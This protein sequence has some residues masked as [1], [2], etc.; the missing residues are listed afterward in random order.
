V[1]TKAAAIAQK[2]MNLYRNASAIEG[3][4][5]AVNPVL[6]KEANA[7]VMG[8]IERL[9][10][11]KFLS[12]HISDLKSGR[13]KMNSIDAELVP[14]GANFAAPGKISDDEY[15]ELIRAL[16]KFKPDAAHLDVIKSLSIVKKF[17]GNWQTG[18]GSV[19]RDSD[20][21][22]AWQ[23]VV[24]TDG[25]LRLWAR[26]AGILSLEPTE[27]LRAEVQAD[28]PEYETYLPMFGEEGKTLLARIRK[29][30]NS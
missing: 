29:L 7:A 22:A 20:G 6:M 19:L 15:D 9:P 17:E 11:G 4:W 13:T 30:I 8:E 12:K 10:C 27:L 1:K 18:V 21:I 5:S 28:L 16:G 14:C 24:R 3:A 25:A 2:L 23:N 26:A